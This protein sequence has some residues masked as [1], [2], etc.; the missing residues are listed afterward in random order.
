MNECIYVNSHT[1]TYLSACV[2]FGDYLLT[3][4]LIDTTYWHAYLLTCILLTTYWHYLLTCILIDI[5]LIDMHT[6][7]R[8]SSSTTTTKCGISQTATKNQCAIKLWNTTRAVSQLKVWRTWTQTT[9]TLFWWVFR[10]WKCMYMYVYASHIHLRTAGRSWMHTIAT[11][12]WWIFPHL[13]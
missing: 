5:L 8:S 7:E 1:H 11:L 10:F 13:D 3:C 4:I 9:A 12:L 2:C 6:R